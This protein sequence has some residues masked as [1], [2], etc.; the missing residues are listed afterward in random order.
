MWTLRGYPFFGNYSVY[1][2]ITGSTK[3]TQWSYFLKDHKKL[4]GQSGELEEELETEEWGSD[5]NS[6]A[7]MSS[8]AIK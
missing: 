4:G 3:W 8:H 6:Y 1:T 2:C 7:Y 5:Q